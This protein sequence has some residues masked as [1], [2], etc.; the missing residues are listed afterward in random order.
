LGKK[1]RKTRFA[2]LTGIV[3]YIVICVLYQPR[4][5]KNASA[6]VLA[7]RAILPLYC[8]VKWPKNAIRQTDGKCHLYCYLCLITAKARGKKAGG[9]PSKPV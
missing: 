9:V 2:K 5:I 7:E 4:H 6:N 8:R 3:I 1:G